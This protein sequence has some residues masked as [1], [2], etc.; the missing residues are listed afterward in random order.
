MRRWMRDPG[1]AMGSKRIVWKC[2]GKLMI[3][4][5]HLPGF[6]K[7]QCCLLAETRKP[8]SLERVAISI[9][10]CC[11]FVQGLQIFVRLSFF[12]WNAHE[13][14]CFEICDFCKCGHIVLE[15]LPILDRLWKHFQTSTM[16]VEPYHPFRSPQQ[17]QWNIAEQGKATH[18]WK[19]L[20]RSGFFRVYI[21]DYAS[22]VLDP[23]NEGTITKY[24]QLWNP[25]LAPTMFKQ[26]FVASVA[27]GELLE[28]LNQHHRLSDSWRSNGLLYY[29][30]ELKVKNMI[31]WYFNTFQSYIDLP[32]LLKSHGNEAATLRVFMCVGCLVHLA[33]CAKVNVEKVHVKKPAR[34][35]RG[36]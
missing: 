6:P 15:R 2:V 24:D 33:G 14:W 18:I 36:T 12:L 27:E 7:N 34:P 28:T 23:K 16:I 10:A 4:G 8:F 35:W 11:F 13:F 20:S 9:D 26:L 19:D 22:N 31:L 29:T 1:D 30:E 3:L 25:L 5:G 21:T 17:E 32:V